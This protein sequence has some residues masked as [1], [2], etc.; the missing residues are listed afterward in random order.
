MRKRKVRKAR[1]S[2]NG[3]TVKDKPTNSKQMYQLTEKGLEPLKL[4]KID[5]VFAK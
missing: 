4:K 3:M 2:K 5:K 1:T